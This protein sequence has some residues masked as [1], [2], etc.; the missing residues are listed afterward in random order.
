MDHAQNILDIRHRTILTQRSDGESVTA[1]TIGVAEVYVVR[2][3]TDRQAIISV[4]DDVVLEQHIR[5]LSG[6]TY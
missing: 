5:S 4:E 6:E 3:A 1:V 2:W